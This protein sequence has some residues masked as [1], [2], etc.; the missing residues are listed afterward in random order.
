MIGS[1]TKRI[2][3]ILAVLILLALGAVY[4]LYMLIQ[5][6]TEKIVAHETEQQK[7]AA[8]VEADRSLRVYIAT[9][10]GDIDRLSSRIVA[11]DGTV[12]F[13]EMIEGLARGAGLKI[14]VDAVNYTDS[15]DKEH[16]ENLNLNVATQGSWNATNKFLALLETLPYKVTITQTGLSEETGAAGAIPDMYSAQWNGAFSFSVIK[17]K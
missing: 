5:H 2:C 1:T 12:A 16:F 11:K 6:S 4:G 8:E 15:T 9:A 3:I 17:Y 7:L 10:G 14:T 13:I